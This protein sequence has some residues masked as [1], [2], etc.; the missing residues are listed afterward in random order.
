MQVRRA[1]VEEWDAVEAF[2]GAAYEDCGKSF[3]FAK[4]SRQDAWIYVMNDA[5][6]SD[7]IAAASVVVD[8]ASSTATIEHFAVAPGRQQ[9]GI[10]SQFVAQIEALLLDER[11]TYEHLAFLSDASPKIEAW[12][13]AHAFHEYSG[14]FLP[15]SS[16]RYIVY[17][18][19]LVKGETNT[20]APDMMGD[21]LAQVIDNNMQSEQDSSALLSSIFSSLP[22]EKLQAVASSLDDELDDNMTTSVSLEASEDESLDSLVRLLMTQLKDPSIRQNLLHE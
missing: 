20:E 10:G 1:D 5:H 13:E 7:F 4:H 21:F 11:P 8:D 3:P 22:L 18:K 15:D 17:R 6:H 19:H 14:G 2:L 9:Q 16:S 12:A